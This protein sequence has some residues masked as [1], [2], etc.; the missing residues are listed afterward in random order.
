MMSHPN[1]E[2]HDENYQWMKLKATFALRFAASGFFP[3][4]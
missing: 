2:N 1:P 4:V 3:E